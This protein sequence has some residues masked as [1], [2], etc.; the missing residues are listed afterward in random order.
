MEAFKEGCHASAGAPYA[1]STDD[2]EK[3]F[4][5]L[6]KST[7]E[8]CNTSL[9]VGSATQKQ[10]EEDLN[11]QITFLMYVKEVSLG[12]NRNNGNPIT[13]N[14]NQF[15]YKDASYSR[16]EAIVVRMRRSLK[17][18]E[19]KETAIELLMAL[20]RNNGK[21]WSENIRMMMDDEAKAKRLRKFIL[22]VNKD[23]H[24]LNVLKSVKNTEV[25]VRTQED[26]ALTLSN[27]GKEKK[28]GLQETLLRY[29]HSKE[30]AGEVLLHIKRLLFTYFL[31]DL[32]NRENRA[33]KESHL[34]LETLWKFHGIG[35][36]L[37]DACF[38]PEE[39]ITR[40]DA[41]A[42][43]AFLF[44]D[45]DGVRNGKKITERV[46]YVNYGNYLRMKKQCVDSFE[47]YWFDY[48]KDYI[49]QHYVTKIYD[50]RKKKIAKFL[51]EDDYNIEIMLKKCWHD[52][53]RHICGKYMNIGKAV[54]HFMLPDNLK[55]SIR[56]KRSLCIDSVK[57]G[58]ENGISSFDYEDIKAEENLQKTMF[59]VLVSAVANFSRSV[60]DFEGTAAKE[61]SKKLASENKILNEDVLMMSEEHL[62]VILQKDAKRKLLRYF[63]GISACTELDNADAMNL[64]WE[65]RGILRSLR[66]EVFHYT[67]GTKVDIGFANT[68]L[69]WKQDVE[70]NKQLILDKYYSNNVCRY[71]SVDEVKRF[72][73]G[74]YKS[75]SQR[76]AQIPALRT[77]WKKKDLA[78]YLNTLRT[79]PANIRD[80][81]KE[82]TIFEGTFYFL[83]KEI[84]YQDFT[85]TDAAAKYFFEAVE[86]YFNDT[87]NDFKNKQHQRPAESFWNYVKELKRAYND[88]K[89]TFG[90][91]CQTI[92]TEY[93]Q[94]NA[95]ETED[96]EKIYQHFNVL[97]PKCIQMGFQKFLADKYSF[98]LKP[99]V[100]NVDAAEQVLKDVSIE[101]FNDLNREVTREEYSWYMLAHFIHP[102]KLNQFVGGLKDYVQFKQDILRR[103]AYAKAYSKE[104]YTKLRMRTEKELE[105]ISVILRVLEFVRGI[106]G[107][108]S[109]TFSDYYESEDD[110]ASYM[111]QYIEF[112]RIPGTS[113][114]ES[115]RDF[116]VNTLPQGG[117][118]DIYTDEKNPKL[119][120]NV[121]IA[122][123][124]AGG[125]VGLHKRQ[126]VTAEELKRY[127]KNERTI[128]AILQKGLCK[129]EDEQRRVLSQ[130]KLKNRITLNDVTV[131]QEIISDMLSQL[132]TFSY[133][134]E[135]DEMYLLLGF[136]YMALQNDQGRGWQ[137]ENMD[138]YISE[139]ISADGGFVLYQVVSVFT[140]GLKFYSQLSAKGVDGQLS[141][142]IVAFDKVHHESLAQALCLFMDE[143]KNED[144][145]RVVRNYVDHFKYYVKPD[146]S[147]MDLYS[148][149]YEYFFDYS[150]KMRKSVLL[151][152]KS[153]L[154]R[155]F[156]LSDI[157]MSGERGECVL[158]PQL[159]SDKFTYKLADGKDMKYDARDKLFLESL[160]A[161]LE[162]SMS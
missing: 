99:V 116:C 86:K 100:R 6:L 129:N 111:K 128:Q 59:G 138:E 153:I 112:E 13:Q 159:S 133:F 152:F 61:L 162:Y 150:T 17:K 107:R 47:L 105:R 7:A 147:I 84:Y 72:I 142:K 134:R 55:E 137:E 42:A 40:E 15:E 158:E 56:D 121:E 75:Y 14:I 45:A 31:G 93:N 30:S 146:R 80:D 154:E 114:F 103:S 65:F 53:I 25:A 21:T 115:F 36:G 120:K 90:I 63:G 5:Q 89:I 145:I 102:K 96:G 4:T 155:Y 44:A 69:L 104:E 117:V 54:Y 127:Y 43:L 1:Y 49:E 95:K 20:S 139:R 27:A 87:K 76:E 33:L 78:P 140:Y 108:V 60:A 126:I 11:K 39:R 149:Y 85:I 148:V 52:M 77:I 81:V 83:L 130:Q 66:N 74:A 143:D 35:A 62:K 50:A 119:L 157:Q 101:C 26:G 156:V 110:Y 144:N 161:E 118:M 91:V 109:N 88:G 92:M 48:I 46:K 58:Y 18:G 34:T 67:D 132:V 73:T 10:Q 94:Q 16:M 68:K 160:K 22:E 135:R 113:M 29:A 38:V 124:Y 37:F 23:Y 2:L 136:Y 82:R 32:D 64:A 8:K 71:Y 3:I 79:L 151:N 24:H 125:D 123:M 141:N 131:I 28:Q 12:K 57:A 98:L 41:Q 19:L 97:F 51:K 122:R 9:Y 106:T 70:A